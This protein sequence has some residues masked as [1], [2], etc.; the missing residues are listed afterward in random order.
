MCSDDHFRICFAGGEVR[1]HRNRDLPGDSELNSTRP[2][3][4][5]SA[6][7]T[8]QWYLLIGYPRYVTDRSQTLSLKVRHSARI[9]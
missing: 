4:I 5:H 7:L 8:V 2:A 3:G 9:G 6:E 1:S